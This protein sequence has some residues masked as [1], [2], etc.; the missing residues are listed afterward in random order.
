MLRL[1]VALSCL[2]TLLICQSCSVY[3]AASQPA[4]VDIAALQA[5]GMSRDTVISRIGAPVSSTKNA[6]GTR[7]DVYVFYEGSATGWKI[8]RA[9]FNLLADI[10]TLALWE[11]IATPTEM[12]IKGSEVTARADYDKNDR[13]TMFKILGR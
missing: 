10:A 8:G 4:K 2:V 5:G 6:D 13:V 12:A 9:T 11:A 3:L 7:F 1:F